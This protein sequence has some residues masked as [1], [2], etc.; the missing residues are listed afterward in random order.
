MTIVTMV[1]VVP[2]T[3]ERTDKMFRQIQVQANA[4]S[5]G[6]PAGTPMVGLGQMTAIMSAVAVV[7]SALIASVY[8]IVSLWFLTRPP[9]RAAC[10]QGSKPSVPEFGPDLEIGCE[11][12]DT[13]VWAS[14]RY[15]SAA[16]R[17]REA[18]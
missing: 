7:F 2:I 5:G 11:P 4:K 17:W 1:L 12:G 3:A 13:G 8:P 6:P 16:V 15:R 18:G 10:L 9:T 14:G